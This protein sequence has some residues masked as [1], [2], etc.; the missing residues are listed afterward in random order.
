[1]AKVEH[2]SEYSRDVAGARFQLTM[3]RSCLAHV[4]N[5]AT[6]ALISEHT[7]SPTTSTQRI[8]KHM[9]QQVVT[10]W[11]VV[12]AIVVK[13]CIQAASYCYWS[14]KLIVIKERSSSKRKAMWKT[15]QSKG[16][17]ARPDPNLSSTNEG[18]L[19]LNISKCCI[20][21]TKQDSK[22]AVNLVRH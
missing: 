21:L 10:R 8:L 7:A 20:G 22:H 15:V 17:I 18:P 11:A 2:P 14:I 9:F 19:V 1:L 4:I 3:F 6:Q 13:V 5:L 16:G 12:R